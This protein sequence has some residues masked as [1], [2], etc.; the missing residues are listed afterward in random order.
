MAT[1]SNFRQAKASVSVPI[2]KD[3]LA[4]RLSAV[5]TYRDGDIYNTVRK[6]DQN[7]RESETVRG[8]IYWQAT[9]KL[10]VR[11]AADYTAQQP[12]ARY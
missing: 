2:V 1:S 9:D 10:L 6:Q 3:V 4:V 12:R 11:F 8:Q 5:A 7:A